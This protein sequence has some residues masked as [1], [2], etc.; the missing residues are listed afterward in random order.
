[1]SKI[2][3]NIKRLRLAKGFT[4]EELGTLMGKD[5]TAVSNW[6]R[7]QN[8]MTTDDLEKLCVVLDCSPEELLGWKSPKE[9][10][11]IYA[12]MHANEL[13]HLDSKK[14]AEAQLAAMS[15]IELKRFLRLLHAAKDEG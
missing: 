2:A 15:P 4:Q 3:E 5:K 7:S 14:E 10:L 9:K 1:M 13:A 6:E 8:K 11:S 12:D